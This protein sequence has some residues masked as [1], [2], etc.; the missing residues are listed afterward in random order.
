MIS[1]N[2]TEGEAAFL[3]E[4]VPF[5]GELKP[6]YVSIFE[7]ANTVEPTKYFVPGGFAVVDADSTA[8]ITVSEAIPVEDID[9]EAA[10]KALAAAEAEVAKAGADEKAAAEAQILVDVYAAIVNA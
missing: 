10:K 2:T 1:V 8:A 6:G 9:I 5:L 3:A 4:H 7:N